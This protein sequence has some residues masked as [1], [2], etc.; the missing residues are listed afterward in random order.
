MLPAAFVVARRAQKL[1]VRAGW[2]ICRA[3][4]NSLDYVNARNKL[5]HTNL[6][7]NGSANNPAIEADIEGC[8]SNGNAG[9]IVCAAFS[10]ITRISSC[11]AH[12][13]P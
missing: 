8:R 5:L 10:A 4:C 6:A 12:E 9:C 7:V 2:Q 13:L 11:V 1:P 3:S